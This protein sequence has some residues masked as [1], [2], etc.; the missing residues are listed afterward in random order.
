MMAPAAR[1]TS[2]LA[3]AVYFA[4][5]PSANSIPKAISGKLEAFT[6]FIFVT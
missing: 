5:L 6:Q 3:D 1:M 4:P 2:L